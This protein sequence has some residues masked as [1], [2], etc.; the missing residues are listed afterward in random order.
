MSSSRKQRLVP[1]LALAYLL[2]LPALAAGLLWALLLTGISLG[3][4][5][6]FDFPI[7]REVADG[8]LI[9]TQLTILMAVASLMLGILPAVIRLYSASEYWDLQGNRPLQPRRRW[10]QE[11]EAL[12]KQTDTPKTGL[13]NVLGLVAG[14]AISFLLILGRDTDLLSQP[15]L[16]W[17]SVQMVGL[18]LL[19]FRGMAMNRVTTRKRRKQVELAQEVDLLDLAPQFRAARFALRN[20]MTW[21]VGGSL[22]S[23]FLLLE[24]PDGALLTKGILVAVTL[25]ATLSLLPTVLQLQHYIRQAKTKELAR[26]R[27]EI[28]PLRNQVLAG[29][30]QQGGR[31]ADLLTYLH[32]VETLPEL[33]FDKGRV[34]TLSLYFAVPLGSWLWISGV[35]TLLAVFGAG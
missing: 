6:M 18:M 33:P 12:R 11:K 10:K 25:F 28:L 13:A 4:A 3:M 24:G 26:L 30:E 20:G 2:P 34:A 27:A 16:V 14:L 8:A 17:A 5:W 35:Q 9:P 32:Y 31:L 1:E 23:L 7:V 15:V 22:S 21:L 29:E 19:L